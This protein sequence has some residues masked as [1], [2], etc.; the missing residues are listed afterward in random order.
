MMMGIG[1]PFAGDDVGVVA[2]GGYGFGGECGEG[3]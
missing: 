1:V 3:G 2:G